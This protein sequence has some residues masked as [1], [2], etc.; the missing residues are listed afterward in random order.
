MRIST[1]IGLLLFGGVAMAQEAREAHEVEDVW[2]KLQVLAYSGRAPGVTVSDRTALD[3]YVQ[4]SRAKLAALEEAWLDD[5]CVNNNVYQAS[6][7][8]LVKS[9]KS[10]VRAQH[11]LLHSIMDGLPA[12]VG[13]ETNRAFRQYV[14]ESPRST[15]AGVE[16]IDFATNERLREKL[17]SKVCN[18]G[19]SP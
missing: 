12:A 11:E 18:R 5:L 10:Y 8:Q 13:D 9:Q 15:V 1:L 17:L 6:T 14:N 7:E 4:E 2:H 19:V 3:Q 16:T